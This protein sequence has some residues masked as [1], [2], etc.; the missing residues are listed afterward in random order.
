MKILVLGCRGMLGTALMERLSRSHELC[1]RDVDDFDIVSPVDC[2]DV[3][4]ETEPD[5]V[6]NAAAYTDVDGCETHQ[7]ECFAV[8]AAGV[9]NVA[10]VCRDR[11][12]KMVHF[13]T[14]YVFDG[15]SETPY[16]ETDVCNPINT[17]G[18]SK[19]E[20]E[21][22]LRETCHDYILIRTA[23][24][25]GKKGK[26]F[27]TAVLEKAKSEQTLDVVNDQYGSPTYTVDLAGAVGVLV[28]GDHRGIFHL[29]NRGRCSWY[30]FACKIMEYAHM[31]DVE[32]NPIE[33]DRLTRVA[34]R[35][36]YSVL[37]C[38][39]FAEATQKTMRF[40]QIALTDY[41]NRINC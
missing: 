11:G 37:R 4:E 2:R 3:I 23:W 6:V 12:I 18:T 39:K 29:T 1:G 27:V 41:M 32:I 17:Y 28:E 24:L 16:A 14:D 34:L 30:E 21:R 19:Y 35:P 7:D 8:N 40:W 22:Y 10:T 31:D 25:Y 26:N 13:S 36:R 20:G 33:S 5:V 9:R 38:R 15:T